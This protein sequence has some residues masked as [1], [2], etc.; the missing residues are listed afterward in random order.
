MGKHMHVGVGM[1]VVIVGLA[2]HQVLAATLGSDTLI[3]WTAYVRLVERALAAGLANADWSVAADLETVAPGGLERVLDG[4]VNV[5]DM[6]GRRPGPAGEVPGGL[7]HHWRG[8][9]FVPNVDLDHVLAR[10]TDPELD[11][12][13]QEDVLAARVLTRQ[14]DSLRLFLRLQRNQ[15][16]TVVYN[17]QHDVR[18]ARQG[19]RRAHSRSVSTRIAEVTGAGTADERER[20]PGEDRGFLWRLNSYWRYEQV[21]GGVLVECESLS[22]SR[23]APP[24]VRNVIRPVVDDLARGAMERT[25]RGVRTRLMKASGEGV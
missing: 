17:T 10:V 1:V 16:V 20:R 24:L 25:L 6:T 4:S 8:V 22:L 5:V 18:W 19:S 14:A 2:G 3:G 21:Q 15:I 23:T 13:L 11:A 9:V 7:V 12:G